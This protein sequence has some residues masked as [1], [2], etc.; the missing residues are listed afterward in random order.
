LG[1]FPN[2]RRF[3][4]VSGTLVSRSCTAF[5]NSLVICVNGIIKTGV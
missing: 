5:R 2:F 4:F 1:C 3:G